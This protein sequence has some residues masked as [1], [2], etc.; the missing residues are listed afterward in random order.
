MLFFQRTQAFSLKL[1]YSF[2]DQKAVS[3]DTWNSLSI[4]LHG[5]LYV[6]NS[7]TECA[8]DKV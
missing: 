2:F 1:K 8:A 3:F 7:V 5:M 4:E 6:T